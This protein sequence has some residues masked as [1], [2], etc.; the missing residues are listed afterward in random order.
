M[1]DRGHP[2]PLPTDC[3][4]ALNR[5]SH[6]RARWWE[7]KKAETPG[8]QRSPIFAS[9]RHQQRMLRDSQELEELPLC[10]QPIR[11]TGP[12]LRPALR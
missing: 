4:Q 10:L 3:A 11:G 5:S 1:R 2:L 9:F 6:M 12:E 7:V 8:S